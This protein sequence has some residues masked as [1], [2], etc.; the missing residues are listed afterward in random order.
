MFRSEAVWFLADKLSSSWTGLAK[1]QHRSKQEFNRSCKGVSKQGA[2][3]GANK[4]Q[5]EESLKTSLHMRKGG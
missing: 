1:A 2:H 3:K 5:S 4:G